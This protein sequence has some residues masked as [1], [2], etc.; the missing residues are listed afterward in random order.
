MFKFLGKHAAIG[1][2]AGAGKAAMD[3]T[4]RQVMGLTNR[5]GRR[6]PRDDELAQSLGVRLSLGSPDHLGRAG[7]DDIVVLDLG[8]GKKV[9]DITRGVADRGPIPVYWFHPRAKEGRAKSFPAAL[10][11]LVKTHRSL[12]GKGRAAGA[13]RPTYTTNSRQIATEAIDRGVAPFWAERLREMAN[14]AMTTHGREYGDRK[15][16]GLRILRVSKGWPQKGSITVARADGVKLYFRLK[17]NTFVVEGAGGRRSP[18]LPRAPRR[19]P[20]FA[21]REINPYSRRYTYTEFKQRYFKG[22]NIPNRIAKEFWSDFR[23]AFDGGLQRYIKETTGAAN[24]GRA[25]QGRRARPPIATVYDPASYRTAFAY[26]DGDVAFGTGS[27]KSF[28]PVG[29]V[30]A[31]DRA[32]QH[33]LMVGWVYRNEDPRGKQRGRKG[34]RNRGRRAQDW[35]EFEIEDMEFKDKGWRGHPYSIV[36]RFSTAGNLDVDSAYV[37]HKKWMRWV[38]LDRDNTQYLVE[39][40]S[41][42]ARIL[43]VARR[44]DNEQQKRAEAEWKYL[45][46]GKHG[47]RR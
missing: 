3:H 41:R 33:K 26:S 13:V 35:I 4:V 47:G 11:A 22:E 1:F 19:V 40:P 46:A 21:K 34:R 18:R 27:P 23:Y 9:G 44:Q 28:V 10:R 37:W 38:K 6:G 42:K 5:S 31:K 14:H 25:A 12:E 39:R 29:R 30:I 7:L 8:T 20:A 36:G 32:R 43:A 45:A 16:E 15:V 2:G 24:R 17:R